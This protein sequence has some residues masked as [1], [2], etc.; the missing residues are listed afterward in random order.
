MHDR[1]VW[2]LHTDE[3]DDRGAGRGRHRILHPLGWFELHRYPLISVTTNR[4]GFKI[5]SASIELA[6]KKVWL[7][8]AVGRVFFAD[9][10]RLVRFLHE[11]L[12]ERLLQ[13]EEHVH[14]LEGQRRGLAVVIQ[15]NSE[16]KQCTEEFL[17]LAELPVEEGEA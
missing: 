13:A 12:D 7:R 15:H 8:A 11:Y 10:R 4:G 14:V 1:F 17:D 3:Y 6:G 9:E 5:N 2:V 16:D